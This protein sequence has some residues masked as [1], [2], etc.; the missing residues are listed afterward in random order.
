MIIVSINKFAEFTQPGL[1]TNNATI[2]IK[3]MQYG[4]KDRQINQWNRI[5]NPKLDIRKHEHLV[6]DKVYNIGEK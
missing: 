4:F 5:E 6:Y 1:L 3:T 2:I